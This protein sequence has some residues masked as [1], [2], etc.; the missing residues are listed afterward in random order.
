MVLASCMAHVWFPMCYPSIHPQM[1][2]VITIKTL[3]TTVLP[4]A[5]VDVPSGTTFAELAEMR[6]QELP[7]CKRNK[8]VDQTFT[9]AGYQSARHLDKVSCEVH[10]PID[11]LVELGYRDIVLHYVPPPP[12][13]VATPTR[14]A[15]VLGG[16]HVLPDKYP[17]INA[18]GL[19]FELEL[20]NSI[21]DHCE[22]AGL[23]VLAADK[24]SCAKLL[25]AVRNGLQTIAGRQHLFSPLPGRFQLLLEPLKKKKQAST[26]LKHALVDRYQSALRACLENFGYDT[27]HGSHPD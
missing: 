4:A 6:L 20:F 12:P 13:D 17:N 1:W 8:L 16:Q 14:V 18:P 26:K 9:S 5:A 10:Q 23:S 24:E 19:T 11:G 21:L 22:A 15:P 3:G 25:R 27:R 7:E 2:I